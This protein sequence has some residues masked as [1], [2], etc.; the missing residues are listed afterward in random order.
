MAKTLGEDINLSSW[1]KDTN[2]LPSFGEIMSSVV[3]SKSRPKFKE[4]HLRAQAASLR[5]MVQS[6]FSEESFYGDELEGDELS[7]F[8]SVILE[9]LSIYSNRSL[10]REETDLVDEC[11]ICLSA[12]TS[13]SS[14]GRLLVRNYN[15][16]TGYGFKDISMQA[17]SSQSAKA[18]R[19]FSEV[20][21]HLYED[22]TLWTDSSVSFSVSDWIGVTGLSKMANIC[23]TKLE[24]MFGPSFLLGEVHGAAFLGSQCV[25]A[26]RLAET[27][28]E[29][30][31]DDGISNCWKSCA[32][33]VSLLGKGL[34]H[35]DAAIGNACSRAVVIAFSYD[36]KD[37]PVLN[38]KLF[39][40]V[41]V[42]L[43]KMNASLKR[44][45]SID[46]AD[47]NRSASLIQASGLLL[48][49]S[50][51]GAGSSTGLGGARLQ[52]V[53]SLFEIL[54]SAVYKKDDELSLSVGEALVKYADAF[55]QGEWSSSGSG[56]EWP[57]GSY[58][59]AFAFSLPPHA[60]ILYTL[61]E[62]EL[63]SSN[64]MKK[65]SC[66]P[67]MLAV[68]AHASRLCNIDA[69]FSQRAMIREVTK[70]M[71]RFQTN[72]IHLLSHPKATQL[73][74]ESC[75]R[76]I[77][78][79]R[80]LSTAISTPATETEAL[81]ERL[82]KAFGETS[83]YGG[84]AMIETAAQARE[85]R[86]E[87]D[88]SNDV[89]SA[90]VGGTSGLSEAALGAYREM[91]SA[92]VSVDRPDVLYSLMMLSTSH[93]VWSQHEARDRYGAKS[94]L[95]KTGTNDTE[96]IRIA[97]RPHL[98]KLIPRLLRACNDPNKQ[99]RE[100]MNN[101]WIA[102]TGGGAESRSLI[103]QHFL[104][105]LDILIEEAGSKLWRARVG[106]C[107]ALA[108]IIVGR[109]W[110]EL[111]G[112][113]VDIDDEG[114]GMKGVTASI[115]LL[116]LW[117][118]TMRALDDVRTPVRERGDT[119]GRG[120]RALTIRLC[121]PKAGENAKEEEEVYLSNAER[122]RREK[123]NDINSEYAATVSLGWLVKYGLNQPCA[124]A[125]GICISCLL[126]I[127]DVSK[128]T[129]LQPVLA[130][131]IGSLLMA[132]SGLEPSALN[133]LQVRA[134][135]NESSQGSTGATGYDR[136]ERLRIQLASSGPIAEVSL[137]YA[138]RNISF[139]SK[140]NS[141]SIVSNRHSINA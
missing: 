82:L 72:F 123:E 73:S 87:G 8:L 117:R 60:H 58:N 9:T 138:N 134:A 122:K 7:I 32:D 44:F 16:D 126:G 107:G 137:H 106:A 39:D 23:M 40:G 78:A 100:Q 1:T 12:C 45:A 38:K 63:K 121:D 136:L 75:C 6:F 49:A 90:E 34:A 31:A 74:R 124:E 17:L 88:A 3:R 71:I 2:H 130:E 68:V 43:D 76:G 55:G 56:A 67:V 29:Q 22:H 79:L 11:S 35:T 14:E 66:A 103:S 86:N 64:P 26:F 25:R 18:R 77:A 93:E 141:L 101:L 27:G 129:T 89:P 59:E 65:N 37:A 125:T 70:L 51:S 97:L 127:V 119:L 131:L 5:F 92:A 57:A 33:I 112:G 52:C 36:G 4:F 69:S 81:N 120:V 110:G 108:D 116:R 21:G 61:F 104:T 19:H 98:G 84:S 62:R 47:A 128:P 105:T 133:Y 15:D 10:S 118:I 132:M 53:D 50:T 24:S 96:E 83:N 114:A 94:I 80:G 95:G 109:S 115:R 28:K 91:A 48:A 20:V 111:G 135:G 85:R 30:D 54:G 42:A 139:S 46:H 102:L 113:G 99:T 140:S 13:S 41:A